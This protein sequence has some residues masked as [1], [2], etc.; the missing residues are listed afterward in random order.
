MDWRTVGVNVHK[1]K[2][3]FKFPLHLGITVGQAVLRSQ[4]NSQKIRHQKNPISKN[5]IKKQKSDEK[6]SNI[7]NLTQKSDKNKNS[8][9][10]YCTAKQLV[11]FL[12]R[13]Q[14]ITFDW[15]EVV[16]RS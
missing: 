14:N 15:N 16:S 1:W 13:V 4:N 5:P 11:R 3:G 6:N 10:K 7:K 8:E 9:P 2:Y 12:I